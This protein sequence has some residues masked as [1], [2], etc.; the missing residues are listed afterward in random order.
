MKVHKLLGNIQDPIAAFFDHEHLLERP[1]NS[2]RI[3]FGLVRPVEAADDLA[4]RGTAPHHRF[5]RQGVGV[6]SYDGGAAIRVLHFKVGT[7][8]GAVSAPL[9]QSDR[10]GIPPVARIV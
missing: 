7:Q 5:A 3:T 6:A 2:H 10:R 4:C 8:A 1:Q 9:D